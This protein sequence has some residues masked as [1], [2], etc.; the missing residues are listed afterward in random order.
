VSYLGDSYWFGIVR[1]FIS[2]FFRNKIERRR[3]ILLGDKPGRGG[4]DSL[5]ID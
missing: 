4:R 3:G 1:E 5:P 2:S